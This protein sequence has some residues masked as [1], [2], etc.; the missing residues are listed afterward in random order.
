MKKIFVLLLIPMALLLS[1]CK[2]ST[3]QM[4]QKG[5]TQFIPKAAADSIV[6]QLIKMNGESNKTL[7]EKGVN[8]VAAL[9]TE[10]DGTVK[11]FEA[12]CLKNYIASP[13]MKEKIFQ[14]IST[15]FETLNGYFNRISLDLKRPMALDMG[16]TYPIDEIFSAYEPTSHFNDDFF[17]NKIGFIVGLNFP[18]YTLEEKGQLGPK[19]SRLEWAYARLGDQF[20]TR[21][22]ADIVQKGS[23]ALSAAENYISGYNIYMGNLLDDQGKTHFPKDM[24]LLSHWNLRDEIKANYDKTAEGLAKQ[25]MIYQ[26]ML[27]I[28]DQSI[29]DSVINNASF[30]W[31]PVN[32]KLYKGGK[33]VTATPEPDKRYEIL[34]NNF[35]AMKAVDQYDPM[36]PTYI[37]RA[38]NQQ[39]E[40]PID[41]VQKLFTEFC[42]TPEVKK[43]GALIS[44]RLGRPLQPFDIWYDGFKAR[45]TMDQAMLD[46]MTMKKYPNTDAVEK[47]I[48]NILIK[49]GFKPEKAKEIASH[50]TVDPARGSGHAWGTQMK[51]DKSHLRTR[52]GKNGM[53]Y[54]GYNIAVHELG[55]NIEQT[56]SMYMVD[57]YLMSGVPNTAFTEAFAFTFQKRDLDLLGIKD[58]D[59]NKDYLDALDN[60]WMCYEIMGVSMLDMT[61]WQWMYDHPDAT[62]AQLKETVISTSKDVWN[63]YYADVLGVKD[64]PILAIYSHMIEDPLYLSNYPV[65]HLIDFQLETW[66]KGKNFADEAIRIY[67][68]GKLIPQEWMKH[69]VGS[70]ISIKPLVDATDAALK[71]IK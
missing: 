59:P 33:E 6:A 21:V 1:Q 26:V 35:K 55:H 43:V 51:G 67:S 34:L 13:E 56:I 31:N 68:A 8:Q 15:N 57:N 7:I 27:R 19:W 14:R 53:D 23:D 36:F 62:P 52:V 54:K 20:T 9:W 29:P 25:K 69:A 22:P 45:S 70:E 38:F 50:I 5:T 71:V 16:E 44:K 3:Q 58:N 28:I 63:K 40:I 46:K 48:P 37:K 39:M 66:F 32:N 64:C 47:D 49:L 11:D 60:F 12:F 30:Q 65:G 2:Q 24:K 61:V 42:S 18:F 4:E 10:K 17:T 41:Q